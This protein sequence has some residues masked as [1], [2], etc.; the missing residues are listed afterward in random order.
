LLAAAGK[1]RHFDLLGDDYPTPD[2]T[3][4]RD[5]VHVSDLGR[6]HVQAMQYLAKSDCGSYFN[7]GTGSGVSIRQML[8][9]I[10]QFVGRSVPTIT[11]PRRPGDPAMLIAD[12]KAARQRLGFIP[13]H[14]DL[15]TIIQ[16]AWPTF[17]G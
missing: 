13:T 12:T 6:G 10:E 7:L 9:S 15:R 1:I 5:Y 17:A 16:T 8:A 4:V 2:G 11:R 14:S 3:C